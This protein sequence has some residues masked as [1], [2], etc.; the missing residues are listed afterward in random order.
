MINRLRHRLYE[1]VEL[2]VNQNLDLHIISHSLDKYFIHFQE[3][4]T[5]SDPEIQLLA[6][7]V[8]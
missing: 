1:K 8:T 4:S 5:N 6:I 3:F 7:L 2:L